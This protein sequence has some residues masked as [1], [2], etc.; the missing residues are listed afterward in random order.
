MFEAIVK[1]S[2][3]VVA[4]N[5]AVLAQLS[6]NWQTFVILIGL[7]ASTMAAA[8]LTMYSNN[9]H[10]LIIQYILLLYSFGFQVVF[11]NKNQKKVVGF[12]SWSCMSLFN[13]RYDSVINK[14][15]ICNVK[16]FC[17][18]WKYIVVAMVCIF[19]CI[20]SNNQ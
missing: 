12:V 19:D 7:A 14:R 3:T 18:P 10:N 9:K 15:L 11:A 17:S 4:W 8:N 20:R 2:L 1:P 5:P 13:L 16:L 6:G